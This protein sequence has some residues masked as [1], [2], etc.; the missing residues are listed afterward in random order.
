MIYHDLEGLVVHKCDMIALFILF[1]VKL[2]GVIGLKAGL[3][4]PLFHLKHKVGV[5]SISLPHLSQVTINLS[6][7]DCC[8]LPMVP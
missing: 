6:I 5:Y 3:S 1:Q 7:L 4:I 8:L 2:V